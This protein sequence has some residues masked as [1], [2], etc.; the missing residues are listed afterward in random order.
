M[1]TALQGYSLSFST[2]I[3]KI[4][5]H[6][7]Q[8]GLDYL[9]VVKICDLQVLCT[10]VGVYVVLLGIDLGFGGGGFFLPV[11]NEPGGWR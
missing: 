7:D 1:Y 9:F 5:F 10:I 6:R 3:I 4:S 2:E 11:L 8:S